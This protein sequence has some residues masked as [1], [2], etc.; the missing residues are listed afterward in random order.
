MEA[1]LV[2]G[3]SGFIGMHV[4][5]KL[6]SE[7]YKV[8]GIDNM[9]DYYSVALKKTRLNILQ[10]YKSFYFKQVDLIDKHSLEKVFYEFQPDKV[11]NLAAQAG[12]R[13]SLENPLLYTNTNINGFLNIMEA[14]KDFKVKG[15]VYASSSSVYGNNKS[16]TLDENAILNKPSSIYSF[17]K[18]SNELLANTFNH[19][20]GINVTGLRFFTVYGSWG[21]PDMAIYIFTK[22]IMKGKPI[23]LFNNGNHKRDF[24]YIDDIV[25]GSIS[26]M[27][28]NYANEVFNLGNS[29]SEKLGSVVSIIENCLGKKAQIK[30]KKMQLGDI[31]NT[32]A[33]ISHAKKK[34]AY[35]PKTTIK[36][37]IPKF[38]E[39]YKSYKGLM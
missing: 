37:G 30:F 10:E 14:A 31:K 11:I 28:K 22:N 7:G 36:E 3:C 9:S 15:V 27:K 17:T 19:L 29:R 8:C 18:I 16:D 23:Y 12:V 34:L 21:R 25:N 39:W 6:L 2:T 4:C 26:A 24:T 1:V 20:F 32:L 35:Q 13:Y 38:I 5:K 33:D